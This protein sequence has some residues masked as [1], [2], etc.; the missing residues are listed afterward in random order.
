L[1]KKKF[2]LS[3]MTWWEA[4][5]RFGQTRLAIVPVGSVEQHG[6]HL[7]VGADWIQAWEIARRVGERT[8]VLVLPVMPYGVS[9][10]HKEFPGVI[11]LEPETLQRVVYE[12]LASL[13]RYGVER[14]VFMNG[15]GGNLG[16]ITGAAKGARDDF[17]MLC[18]IVQW[19]DVLRS[20]PVFGHPAE[21]HAGY[22]ETALMLAS[23]PEAVE[24]GYAV[25]TPTRQVD[26][27]I[28]LISAGLAKFRE[29]VVRIPLRTL[30]V[31]DTGSMTEA[32]PDEVPG[33]R[34]YSK[35]TREFAEGLM[36]EVVD[37]LCG[38]VEEFE[39]FELPPLKASKEKAMRELSG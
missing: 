12:V 16:A 27:D 4:E 28:Q 9:G 3:S 10:H 2:E 37:W 30:D 22:A 23:R 19:W 17:D 25:L 14:V 31:T 6:L 20:R 8:G 18:A 11:T 29:G 1:N 33:T 34:D 26:E 36:G 24:I 38:F 32:H 15:H 7:G 35:I 21:E 13:N 5:E 39:G